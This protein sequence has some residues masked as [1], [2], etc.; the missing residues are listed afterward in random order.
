MTQIASP[1]RFDSSVASKIQL[2]SD[3]LA[4]AVKL[5]TGSPAAKPRKQQ[6]ALMR[7]LIASFDDGG[8]YGAQAPTGSGKSFAYLSAIAASVI[9]EGKKAVVS[10][11]T[12]QLQSQVVAK[13]LPI[14]EQAAR[15]IAGRGVSYAVLKGRQ[16][17][18][19]LYALLAELGIHSDNALSLSAINGILQADRIN[20]LNVWLS[21]HVGNEAWNGATEDIPL[22][23]GI[24]AESLDAITVGSQ[25]CLGSKCPFNGDG[26]YA[27]AAID[28]ALGA[29]I[30]VTNH[31]LIAIE[32]VTSAPIV[33]RRGERKADIVVIDEAHSLESVV[34]SQE[35]ITINPI[36]MGYA[37]RQVEKADPSI[38]RDKINRANSA[39]TDFQRA[40]SLASD[41]TVNP[42]TYHR[43]NAMFHARLDQSALGL[44]R[45]L[46]GIQRSLPDN[47][48]S[49]PIIKAR[50]R[51]GGIIGA[52]STFLEVTEEQ[53]SAVW[54]EKRNDDTSALMIQSTQLSTHLWSALNERTGDGDEPDSDHSD[55][56]DE[57][58]DEEKHQAAIAAVSATL[59]EFTA[60]NILG[61]DQ[62]YDSFTSP[63][64]KAYKQSRLLIPC[65]PG[66]LLDGRFDHAAHQEWAAS[67]I[68]ELVIAN[69]GS[70]LILSTSASGAQYFYD[71]L[72]KALPES[73]P[74]VFYRDGSS[75]AVV[76]NWK[77]EQKA[78]LVAT[79]GMM[80]GVD[81][82]GLTCTLVVIDRVPRAP[83]SITNE[84][85]VESVLKEGSQRYL[86]EAG[87]YGGD[88]A[89]LLEQ[90][91]GRLIR[92]ES[93]S[94]MLAVLDPRLCLKQPFSYRQPYLRYY[95][96][97][98]GVWGD[99]LNSVKEAVDFL[100]G[101]QRSLIK[102]IEPAK[103]FLRNRQNNP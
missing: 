45:A 91:A 29:D 90:A 60:R 56:G 10:T 19:C 78:V 50:S 5:A 86:A 6:S 70:A 100:V 49:P 83:K 15:E 77:S 65:D 37:I 96:E 98:L 34:R 18:V 53:Q 76:E 95:R 9:T 52:I 63:F 59:P 74:L 12:R 55:Y 97:A 99:E 26:C 101:R 58:E 32:L 1:H 47:S 38:K 7:E 80:T 8:R 11:E 27:D 73:L 102:D 103:K 25:E 66:S 46:E 48:L 94:G 24:S 89:V 14:I 57:Y 69:E 44:V 21:N 20:P 3:I 43:S 28:A 39:I 51:I 81:A 35:S 79:R 30:I 2:G 84:L 72:K 75:K 71:T 61:R 68:S 62:L 42:S 54:V 4:L 67:V 33:L 17:Y 85:R 40:L 31:A 82:P 36:S 22:G 87:I 64:A 16:N 92:S 41:I 88:A 23:R 13:D 93:D